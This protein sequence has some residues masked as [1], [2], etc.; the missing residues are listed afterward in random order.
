MGF[1]K[2]RWLSLFTLVLSVLIVASSVSPTTL[3]QGNTSQGFSLQ[4]T[5]SPLVAT[6]KP[7]QD[8]TLELRIRNTSSESQSLRMGIRSFN[9]NEDTGQVNLGDSAPREVT[10]FISFSQPTFSLK[11]GE[12]ITQ[13]ILVKTP[14]TAGFTYSFAITVARQTPQRPSDGAAAIE[15]SVAVFT[16]LNV[17]RQGA[18]RKFE[19][20]EFSSQKR[21][22]EYLPASFDLKLKNT[23]NTIIQPRGNIF[24]QRGSND[25]EPIAT[26]P[27]NQGGGYILP[28]TN[29]I[30]NSSW[31]DGFPHYE[32]VSDSNGGQQQKLKWQWNNL[33]NFRIGKYT[34]KVV[35]IYDD[36]QRDVP[37]TTEITFWVIPWKIIG[38]S[39]LI[40][41]LILVGA[42][43][44]LRR[45]TNVLKP[46]KKRH[47]A[48]DETSKKPEA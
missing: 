46:L 39:S 12:I 32:T 37:V 11:S 16:L 17:D 3:A 1:I 10:D 21:V 45:S 29:R 26:L 27:I 9:V 41:L 14:Q 30:L 47:K 15:G 31:N 18:T 6:I 36:G 8:S 22:Y 24:I 44:L 43:T 35:A 28:N 4:V 25:S 42:F 20:G 5:P 33:S 38:I 40:L 2:R 13:K 23:G 19:L 34:A 48:K 7:G